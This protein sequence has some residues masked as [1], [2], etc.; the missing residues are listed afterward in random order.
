MN[1]CLHDRPFNVCLCIKYLCSYM[2]I[3]K[4]WKTL[5]HNYI[6]ISYLPLHYQHKRIF[7][8][9]AWEKMENVEIF[10]S[11]LS[12][13]LHIIYLRMSLLLWKMFK[14]HFLFFFL[15]FSFI[16]STIFSKSRSFVLKFKETTFVFEQT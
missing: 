7:L 10:K 3:A 12:S 16:L 1:I 5:I 15:H 11:F 8:W 14:S 9:V 6:Y 13:L 2:H 4:I